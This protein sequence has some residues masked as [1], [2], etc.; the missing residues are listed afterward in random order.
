M[1][2]SKIIFYAPILEFPPAGGPQQSVINAIRVLNEIAEL[3]VVTSVKRTNL[4][5][6]A[7][8]FFENHSCSITF[9][10]SSNFGSRRPAIDKHIDRVRRWLSF[11][12]AKIDVP[13]IMEVAKEED[14]EIIWVD[15]AVERSFFVLKE[16][17]HNS[18]NH[19][20]V[21]DTEAVH[22]RFILRELPHIQKQFR[23]FWIQLKGEMACKRERFLAKHVDVITAVSSV[24]KAYYEN[25]PELR[26]NVFLFSNVADVE[27]R[28]HCPQK[29]ISENSVLLIGSY[30]HKHSPMDRA[31]DWCCKVIFPIVWQSVPDAKLYIIGRNSE[32]SQKHNETNNVE[33][34]GRVTSMR[35]WLERAKLTVVPLSHESGTRFK[36]VESGAAGVPCVSTTLGAEGIDITHGK[37]ILIADTAE[38]FAES[39]ISVLK[40]DD[41]RKRLATNLH[42]LIKQK[43]SLNTQKKEAEDLISY[44]LSVG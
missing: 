11:A 16:L 3:H 5:D 18:K 13:K 7:L 4:S 35:P 12:F 29:Q 44:L 8:R 14:A 40:N 39:I 37:D 9:L 32:L 27:G 1:D 30:G 15:R 42:A 21:A 19:F 26:A 43:Y 10:P 34:V 31:A 23:R 20:L 36:I 2:R 24:D 22:S 41:L 33:V 25:I 38:A 17:I 6:K 28:S